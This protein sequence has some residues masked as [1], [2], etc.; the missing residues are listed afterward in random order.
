MHITANAQMTKLSTEELEKYLDSRYEAEAHQAELD[1]LETEYAQRVS[2]DDLNMTEDEPNMS[3]EI[4]PNGGNLEL[5]LIEMYRR[6]LQ[7]QGQRD[8]LMD[9]EDIIGN[10]RANLKDAG[11]KSGGLKKVS[12]KEALAAAKDLY[13]H[14]KDLISRYKSKNKLSNIPGNLRGILR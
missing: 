9:N 12:D 1:A 10:I 8:G 3:E 11:F 2:E 7:P 13:E 6:Y 14:R 4:G 5:G